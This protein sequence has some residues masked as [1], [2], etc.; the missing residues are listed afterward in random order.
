MESG[1]F[2]KQEE[3]HALQ[4]E[5]IESIEQMNKKLIKQLKRGEVGTKNSILYL[6][7]LNETKNLVLQAGNL[8]KSQRDFVN[9]K[10]GPEK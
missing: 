3:L 4:I 7:I 8:Y 1:D 2:S 10:N 9:Y 5:L 6:N